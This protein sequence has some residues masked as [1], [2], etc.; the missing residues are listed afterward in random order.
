MGKFTC[1]FACL[2]GCDEDLLF[3]SL[4]QSVFIFVSSHFLFFFLLLC[5]LYLFVLLFQISLFN[6][7]TVCLCTCLS[8][9]C[10]S[11]SLNPTASSM[12]RQNL[13]SVFLLYIITTPLRPIEATPAFNILSSFCQCIY[14]DLKKNYKRSVLAVAVMIMFYGRP[15]DYLLFYFLVTHCVP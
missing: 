3:A 13:L 5:L 12:V 9:C 14:A 15:W 1:P 10:L 2:F 11:E 8:T 7:N 6:R 4:L